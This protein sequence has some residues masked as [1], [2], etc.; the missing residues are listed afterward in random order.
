MQYLVVRLVF[1]LVCSII[2]GTPVALC[3]PQKALKL[4]PK[5]R[6]EKIDDDKSFVLLQDIKPFLKDIYIVTKDQYAK[7]PAIVDSLNDT[8][9][10]TAG[11]KAITKGLKESDT[12][13]Y[14]IARE[15]VLRRHPI[16]KEALGIE[17][18]VLGNGRNVLSAHGSAFHILNT[19]GDIILGAKLFPFEE[20][21]LPAK[22]HVGRPAQ[23][24][25]GY[26]LSGADNFTA[27]ARGLGDTVTISLGKRDNIQVGNLLT[28]YKEPYKKASKKDKTL[29]AVGQ[30]LIYRI[31]DKVSVG[32]ITSA[33]TGVYEFDKVFS[34]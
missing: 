26:I 24:L 25:E 32:L 17:F 7:A 16:S 34:E 27:R 22:I 18:E 20:L 3:G 13:R 19:Q 2:I 15:G 1:G 30:I 8:A 23:K 12:S 29:L 31:F 6:I 11:S 4:S 33:E 21:K 9:I 10:F 28:I 5:T 14:M